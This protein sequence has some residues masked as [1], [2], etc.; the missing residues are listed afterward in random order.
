MSLPL[1]VK[2]FWHIWLGASP[3]F[4]PSPQLN[5]HP[6]SPDSATLFCDKSW[7]LFEGSWEKV[8]GAGSLKPQRLNSSLLAKSKHSWPLFFSEDFLWIQAGG[9]LKKDASLKSC[10]TWWNISRLYEKIFQ[11]EIDKFQATWKIFKLP[12]KLPDYLYFSCGIF[13]YPEIINCS[14]LQANW[15]LQ[16]KVESQCHLVSLG[17][18]TKSICLNFCF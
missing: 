15:S 5:K 18:A 1:E 9:K 3:P 4:S 8:K 13:F 16:K 6:S 12:G 11:F 14:R 7:I 10:Q 2:W 17:F